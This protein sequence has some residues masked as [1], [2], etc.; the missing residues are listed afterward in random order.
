MALNALRTRF[1]YKPLDAV[2]TSALDVPPRRRELLQGLFSLRSSHYDRVRSLVRLVDS[3]LPG[4]QRWVARRLLRTQLLPFAPSRIEI[5]GAGSGSTVYLLEIDGTKRVLK[6]YRRTLGVRQDRLQESAKFYKG[7][8]DTVA[9]WYHGPYPIVVPASFVILRSPLL[10]CPAVACHQPY[11]DG[12]KHDVIGD[13]DE[14]LQR[15]LEADAG[16]REQFLFFVERTLAMRTQRG[17][18]VDLLGPENL[19]I[20][21]RG[22]SRA[23]RLIDYGILDLPTLER[24]LPLAFRRL[25]DVLN[26][27]E[28]L[29]A[30][31]NET[32]SHRP[33]DSGHCCDDE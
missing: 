16:L 2:L 5:I 17:C 18:C 27:L 25:T 29:A 28:S 13:V 20:T 14:G 26:R 11:L 12:E 7:K 3:L 23:L 8:H 31:L 9:S 32:I 1:F 10:G 30:S 19:L 33:H 15:L 24:E 6:A 4:S 21:D 22:G